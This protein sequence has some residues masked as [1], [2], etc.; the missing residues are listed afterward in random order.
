MAAYAI[1]NLG[2]FL[3]ERPRKIAFLGPVFTKALR[4]IAEALQLFTVLQVT[5]SLNT[6]GALTD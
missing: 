4:P 1:S 3:Q 5:K 6:L 2:A